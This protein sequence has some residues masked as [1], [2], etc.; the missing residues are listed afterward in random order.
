MTTKANVR[1]IAEAARPTI[2]AALDLAEEFAALRDA[3]TAM[4]IDW[5]QLKSLLKA[6]EQDARDGKERVHRIVEKADFA[7]AYADMLGLRDEDERTETEVVHVQPAPPPQAPTKTP[8]A[9]S[10]APEIDTSIPDFLKREQPS[11]A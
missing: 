6:Q 2:R 11:A 1:Q 5:S 10:A 9:I 8:R 4:G 7:S 3:A